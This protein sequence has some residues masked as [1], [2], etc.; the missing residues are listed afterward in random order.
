MKFLPYYKVIVTPELKFAHVYNVGSFSEKNTKSSTSTRFRYIFDK[1]I[2][3][4]DW[5]YLP[6][7]A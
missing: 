4:H 2:S 7:T 5:A 3:L 6:W 1:K